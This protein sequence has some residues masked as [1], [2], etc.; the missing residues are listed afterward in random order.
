MVTKEA[1]I[2]WWSSA[3]ALEGDSLCFKLDLSFLV[4][5]MGRLIALA[6]ETGL[7][8]KWSDTCDGLDTL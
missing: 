5:K 4:C 6:S 8:V 1:A 3:Q 7:R 2:A